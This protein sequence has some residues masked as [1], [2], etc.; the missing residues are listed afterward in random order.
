M[1]NAMSRQDQS[2]VGSVFS[3]ITMMAG[4]AFIPIAVL[5]LL[6]QVSTLFSRW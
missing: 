5:L 6:F 1:N 3:G 4:V 2:S